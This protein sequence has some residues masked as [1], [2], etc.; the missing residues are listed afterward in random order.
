MLEI[1]SGVR[2]FACKLILPVLVAIIWLLVLLL[3]LGFFVVN[4]VRLE[5]I[6]FSRTKKR[7]ANIYIWF[8]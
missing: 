2:S 5:K 7:E 6:L 4:T 1:Q 3:A 8:L